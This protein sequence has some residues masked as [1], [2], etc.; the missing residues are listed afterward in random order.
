MSLMSRPFK[1]GIAI[2][3]IASLS[4]LNISPAFAG[5]APSRASGT[6]TIASTRDADMLVA[7]ARSRIASW[8][9]SCATTA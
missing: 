2:L 1:T 5:L 6:T 8:R 4:T 7:P 3:L 9:R